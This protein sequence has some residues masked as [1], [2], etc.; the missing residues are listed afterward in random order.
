MR[1]SVLAF[2]FFLFSYGGWAQ[3][4]VNRTVSP[5]VVEERIKRLD[6]LT[7]LNLVYNE[8]VQAYID[9]YT[10]KRREHLAKIIG[11]SQLYFPLFEEHLDRLGLPLE[12]KYLAIVESALD[13]QAKSS[14]GA[15]GLWQ[16][17]YHAARVVDLQVSSYVDER[18]DPVKSTDAAARYLKY[19]YENFHDWDLALASYNG[20]IATVNE[21][22]YKSGGQTNYWKIRSFLSDETSSYVAAF[23]AVNYVMTYYQSYGIEP[24]MPPY[25]FDDIDLIYVDKSV[26]F[27]QLSKLMDLD[28]E[29]L[30]L[31]NPV[32]IRDY[33]PVVSTPVRLLVP[34]EKVIVYS[35][36]RNE[37][38][39]E[40]G[41]PVAALPPFGDTHGR[42]RVVHRVARGEFFHR[43]AMVYGCRVEDVQKWNNLKSRYLSAG[44][45]LVIW[46]KP[47]KREP[48]LMLF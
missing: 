20:G 33:V 11:R 25:T 21:A 12:L 22:V 6:A 32:Y 3:S 40:D 31:L 35:R 44:Q 14:S 42:E 41:P 8:A 10:I 15:I 5:Q 43:I 4:N 27:T 30:Q 1:R 17:L 13:P 19:L 28:A 2:C 34:K 24:E 39:A 23:I 38:V 29:T 18:R 47:E 7:P 36:R 45:E 46:R 48:F 26:S 37:L 16:F 9:V